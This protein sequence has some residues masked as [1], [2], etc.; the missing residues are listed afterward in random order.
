VPDV[1]IAALLALGRVEEAQRVR[2]TEV[3]ERLRIDHFRAYLD[4]LP[5][6]DGETARQRAVVVALGH[7]D[8]NA[9]LEFL[10]DLPDTSAAETLAIK[11]TRDFDGRAY[12][13]IKPLAE[14]LEDSHPLAAGLLT[15]VMAEAILDARHSPTYHHAANYICQAEQLAARVSDWRGHESHIDFMARLHDVHRRKSA[16]WPALAAAERETGSFPRPGCQVPE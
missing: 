15:R 4:A 7:N 13:Q 3:T 6:A 1:W 2:W 9:A 10:V 5:V 14:R 12:C 8:A 16:F 11:R